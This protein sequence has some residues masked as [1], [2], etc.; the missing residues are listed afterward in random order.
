MVI[1]GIEQRVRSGEETIE[2]TAIRIED[3]LNISHAAILTDLQIGNVT[4]RTAYL[5]KY[6]APPLRLVILFI[7]CGLE[8][9]E[10]IKLHEVDEA[11]GD[12]IGNSIVIRI[13]CF[14]VRRRRFELVL[15]AIKHHPGPR[16]NSRAVV[17][18]RQ[19]RIY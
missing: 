3:R 9:V 14:A 2:N 12:L 15:A 19:F 7:D 17:C 10:Q 1:D 16:R 13:V 4:L 18:A 8:I 5:T 11:C 6:S